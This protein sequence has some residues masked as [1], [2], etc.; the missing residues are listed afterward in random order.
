MIILGVYTSLLLLNLLFAAI[1]L[2]VGF[3][4][5]AWVCQSNAGQIEGI[6]DE[7]AIVE[8]TTQKQIQSERILLASDRLRDLTM[9][10]VTD[11]GSH[12]EK[13]NRIEEEF[14]NQQ[15]RG[16]SIDVMK[17]FEQ[18]S[19]ANAALQER[20]EKAEKQIVARLKR[21]KLMKP[22]HERTH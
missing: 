13:M 12:A 17:T 22:K 3:A 14:L 2:A 16:Q 4:A 11:V 19:S 21:S 20:L 7:G 9:G 8:G 18:I 6:S 15:E 5:G 1:A 10:V